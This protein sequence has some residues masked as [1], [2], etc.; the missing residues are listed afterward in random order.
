MNPDNILVNIKQEDDSDAMME[1][2]SMDDHQNHEQSS[3]HSYMLSPL[4]DNQDEE[5][6]QE[7]APDT[8]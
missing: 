1:G 8:V 2:I 6:P 3:V 4:E 7:Q 5:D